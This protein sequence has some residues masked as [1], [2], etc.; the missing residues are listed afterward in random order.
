[1]LYDS[2][3]LGL[4]SQTNLGLHLILLTL[5]TDGGHILWF[6]LLVSKMIK[7]L[8][9]LVMMMKFITYFINTLSIFNL[10]TAQLLGHHCEI[11]K[12]GSKRKRQDRNLCRLIRL[13]SRARICNEAVWFPVICHGIFFVVFAQSWTYSKHQKWSYHKANKAKLQDPSIAWTPFQNS[14]LKLVFIFLYAFPYKW[15]HKSCEF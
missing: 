1:M 6:P 5:Y 10:T 3:E 4:C 2:W 9:I 14:V 8:I 13:W 11:R 15:L 7:L 12:L